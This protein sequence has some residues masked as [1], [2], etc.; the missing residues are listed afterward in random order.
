ML[1]SIL[2]LI[3]SQLAV[4]NESVSYGSYKD[5]RDG[6][7][8]RTI[9]MGEQKWISENMRYK[10][11]ENWCGYTDDCKLNGRYY[12]FHTAKNV[13][14]SGYHLPLRKEFDTLAV[15]AGGPLLAGVM[16]KARTGF[17]DWNGLNGNGVDKFGWFAL[18][19]G[20]RTPEG[21]MLSIETHNGGN[22]YYWTS[23]N[24]SGSSGYR[25]LLGH[26]VQ[27][28]TLGPDPI[29]NGF[30][31]RCLN[32]TLF[33]DNLI[34][35]K[36]TDTIIDTIY[37]D[38]IVEKIKDSIIKDT[39]KI[40]IVEKVIDT[41]LNNIYV[42]REVIKIDSIF[43]TDTMRIASCSL[44]ISKELY[45]ERLID[46][47]VITNGGIIISNFQQT[48]MVNV[49][50]KSSDFV[51]ANVWIYD[52]LGVYV[53]NQNVRHNSGEF[54]IS[55]GGVDS[56]GKLVK[57]GIYVIRIVSTHRNNVSNNV[58]TIGVDR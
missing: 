12:K 43:K 42:D 1:I 22:E 8:Y 49:L 29:D 17:P 54:Y 14:P 30:S 58:Y 26:G 53:N 47:K 11:V 16:M 35:K 10:G 36:N 46:G 28:L 48:G 24:F 13:C 39:I 32:D 21:Q 6:N 52:N 50:V 20:R 9:M 31:V 3:F 38:K 57:N 55:W 25:Y 34:P 15:R 23:E 40:H 33:F 19:T 2:G 44:S 56:N 4:P 27:T 41:V 51:N 7:V 5:S 45:V 37:L 18:P